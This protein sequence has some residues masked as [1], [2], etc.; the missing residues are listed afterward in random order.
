MYIYKRKTIQNGLVPFVLFLEL[1][2]G[3]VIKKFSS[4]KMIL[5]KKKMK[6]PH[7]HYQFKEFKAHRK[8]MREIH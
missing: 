1:L 2:I 3:L 4:E 6:I 7:K 8:M 5:F